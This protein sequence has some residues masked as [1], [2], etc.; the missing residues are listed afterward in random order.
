MRWLV[1][2]VV[3]CALGSP[4]V[5]MALG[6][7]PSTATGLDRGIPDY[8][9]LTLII[10]DGATQEEL[11]ARCSVTDADTI[12]RYPL[13]AA[14][15][16]YHDPH[17]DNPSYFY[18]GGRSEIFVPPGSVH[19]AMAHGF[20][21]ETLVDT[22]FVRRDTT[23]TYTLDRWVDMNALGQY[24]GDCHTHIHHSGGIYDVEPEDALFV[25]RAEALNVINCLDNSY[26]FTGGVDAC[27][28]EDC[29][30]YMAEEHRS[31][32][33]GHSGLLGLSS[34]IEPLSTDWWPLIMDVADSTHTQ[35]GAAIIC[36]HPVTTDDFFNLS[37][38]EG[39]MLARE[40]P[41]DVTKY[42]ID[43]Y[44]LLSGN[45]SNHLRTLEMW[46]R[47]LNCGFRMPACAGTDA[48]MNR[49]YGRPPGCMRVY[50]RVPEQFDYWTWLSNLVEGK[51]F[52]TNGPLFTDFQV[53]DFSLGDSVNI[54]SEGIAQLSGRLTVCCESPLRRVD[55]IR[56][57][58]IDQSFWA[59]EGQCVIDTTFVVTVD[60]SSW[61]AA[62]VSGD[63]ANAFTVG[64]SLFAHTGPVY[65]C[66][67]DKRIVEADSAQ[68]LADWVSDVERLAVMHSEW[69][70]PGQSIRLYEELDRA[71]EFYETLAAGALTGVG[72]Q[73]EVAPGAAVL[74]LGAPRPNPAA[75]G[76]SLAFSTPARGHV[77][78]GV[79]APSGRL[80]RTLV[81]DVL[82]PGAH[83]FRWD[84]R[85]PDGLPC[86]A[87]VYLC[88]VEAGGR[89][90]TRKVVL[91]R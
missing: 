90:V 4:Q 62:R 1:A 48:C 57:G 58:E 23:V 46:Y 32:V 40:F 13:P 16:F 41:V 42:K 76:T 54:Y 64:D 9:R 77:R 67:N 12:P 74:S 50:V 72:G 5:S 34:L 82:P 88:R 33:Y 25:A 87:G 29:I 45:A 79:Y 75:A 86:S 31:C 44:E 78:L 10:L 18:S 20:E 30:V 7:Q 80:V 36:A 28:T 55:I 15:C 71:R 47:V 68:E 63:K 37:T 22:I 43:G 83:S 81:D 6:D 61:I 51:T 60:E 35:P 69:T 85:G 8:F 26:Y 17:A 27:S 21:Y 39:G 2:I 49:S 53:R 91:L 84:G 3:V 11:P 66:L 52:V 65:F 70:G 73:D 24:S 56:N 14:E 38:T 59:D 89:T 19:V